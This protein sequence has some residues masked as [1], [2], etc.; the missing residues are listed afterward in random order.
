[1][2]AENNG[3][4]RQHYRYRL[5]LEVRYQLGRGA[6]FESGRG[7]TIDISSGGVL[8]LA[9]V[10]I[11]QGVN[12][13]LSIA[14]PM[15]LDDNS[16]LQLVVRGHVVRTRAND[17]AVRIGWHEFRTRARGFPG[18]ERRSALG[19]LADFAVRFKQRK[20]ICSMRNSSGA[21]R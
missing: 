13:E 11:P 3:E 20:A 18:L 16:M 1:M 15:R 19:Y 21:S 8:F 2:N 14:W 6:S 4:L 9:D 10:P 12:I 7:R 17:A 5:A